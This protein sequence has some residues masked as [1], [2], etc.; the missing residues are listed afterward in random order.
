M[1]LVLEYLNLVDI[2]TMK[3]VCKS[4]Y[5]VVCNYK[6]YGEHQLSE[7]IIWKTSVINS[8]SKHFLG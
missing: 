6:I 3:I 8:F 4:F 7:Q 1:E 5:E 2:N